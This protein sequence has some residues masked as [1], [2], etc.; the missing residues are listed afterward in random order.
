MW[1][2]VIP[3]SVIVQILLLRRRSA[4]YYV[5]PFMDAVL[6]VVATS[7]GWH[8]ED[9]V[10]ARPGTGRGRILRALVLPTLCSAADAASIPIYTTAANERLAAD[11]SAE[12]PGLLDVGRGYPRGRRLRRDPIAT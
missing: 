12:L 1:W 2:L 10:A 11:Y 7:D 9:H 8:I 4:R 3:L 6:A 5:S